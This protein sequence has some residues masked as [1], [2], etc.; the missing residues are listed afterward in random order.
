MPRKTTR[1]TVERNNK[2]LMKQG[3]QQN[4][5]LKMWEEIKWPENKDGQ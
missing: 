3:D 1:I 2:K 4:K 5:A